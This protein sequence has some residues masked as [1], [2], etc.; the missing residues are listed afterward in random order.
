MF[1]GK[2]PDDIKKKGNK[3][4]SQ[5]KVNLSNL[6]RT[7]SLNSDLNFMAKSS[8]RDSNLGSMI[9]PVSLQNL[10]NKNTANRSIKSQ[11]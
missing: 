1:V 10:S 4:N 2:S 6:S 8:F 9:S 11:M 3:G 5:V 7:L